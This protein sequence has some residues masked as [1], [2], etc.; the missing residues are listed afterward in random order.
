MCY[1]I[2][3]CKE[4]IYDNESFAFS[5]PRLYRE[6]N[7]ALSLTIVYYLSNPLENWLKRLTYDHGSG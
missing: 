6:F 3:Q 2:I 1:L 4:S 7:L 5:L